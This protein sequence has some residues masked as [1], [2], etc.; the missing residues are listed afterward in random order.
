MPLVKALNGLTGIAKG[1]ILLSEPL[2]KYTTFKIG[3]PADLLVIPE[4]TPDLQNIFSYINNGSLPRF[5]LGGG[6]NVL[7]RDEGFRGIVIKLN[8]RAF[9]QLSLEYEILRAGAG[10]STAE[11]LSFCIHSNM[12]GL[13]FL[14]GIPGTVGGLVMMNAGIKEKNIS[15]V[16]E[17]ITAMDE[18]GGIKFLKKS[19]MEFGYRSF[20]PRNLTIT[21]ALFKV[22]KRK[23][24]DILS[25]IKELLSRK[26]RTQD[27]KFPSAGCIFKNPD[28]VTRTDERRSGTSPQ[29]GRIQFGS[30][31]FSPRGS[32]SGAITAGELIERAGLKG[33]S[34]GG[35]KIS[36]VH[37][38]FIINTGGAKASDV[39]RL[40]DIVTAKIK[41]DYNI[42]LEPEIVILN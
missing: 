39:M 13:E 12:G 27:L 40:I 7:A 5:V 22:F 35:A 10:V 4:D 37:A 19:D 38:N 1:R 34:S 41:K 32:R 6:S 36:E 3:G 14:S 17:G 21:E 24:A 33:S 8:S 28:P 9:K 20:S 16:I 29:K 31:G 26:N 2:S 23:S 25:E 11:L 30:R 42:E 18:L 15:D